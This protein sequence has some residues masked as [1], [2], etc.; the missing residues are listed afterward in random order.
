MCSVGI[1]EAMNEKEDFF[2]YEQLTVLLA[3]NHHVASD[4]LMEKTIEAVEHSAGSTPQSDDMTLVLV[5]R[6]S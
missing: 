3:Q 1:P 4:E 2:G 6:V 5:R